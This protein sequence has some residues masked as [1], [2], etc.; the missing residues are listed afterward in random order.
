MW[1]AFPHLEVSLNTSLHRGWNWR[2]LSGFP[3]RD[4][5]TNA[6]KRMRTRA[7]RCPLPPGATRVSDLRKPYWSVYDSYVCRNRRVGNRIR[8][9]CAYSPIRAV[10]VQIVCRAEIVFDSRRYNIV[11]TAPSTRYTAGAHT[12]VYACDACDSP[13]PCPPSTYAAQ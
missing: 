3:K 6:R 9:E 5:H 7:L 10:V 8:T 12:Y 2:K 1:V 4:R 11:V 13:L